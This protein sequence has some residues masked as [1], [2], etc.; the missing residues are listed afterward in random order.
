MVLDMTSENSATACASCGAFSKSTAHF[1]AKCGK[2][3][4]QNASP[5]SVQAVGL[6][7]LTATVLWVAA[8]TT[9]RSLLGTKPTE[10]FTS[11]ANSTDAGDANANAG[12]DHLKWPVIQKLKSSL[13]KWP[14]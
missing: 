1:C 14:G 5:L 7:L 12:F 11:R 3:L 6:V 2:R 13:K 8:W 9:Q 10:T 4:G